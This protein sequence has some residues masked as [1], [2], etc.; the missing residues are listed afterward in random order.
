M[1][2]NKQQEEQKTIVEVV[3]PTGDM[4]A[5]YIL[6]EDGQKLLESDVFKRLQYALVNEK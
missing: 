1:L 2:S 4:P 6:A 3:P 5:L